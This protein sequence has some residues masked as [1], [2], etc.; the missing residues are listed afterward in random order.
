MKWYNKILCKIFILGILVNG[1][2]SAALVEEYHDARLA[3]QAAKAINT[4]MTNALP[5]EAL[6]PMP[7][8]L[9]K[10]AVYQGKRM[11]VIK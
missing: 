8:K 6:Q 5:R 7:T 11:M 3:E 1:C 2:M 4:T 9:V 10:V